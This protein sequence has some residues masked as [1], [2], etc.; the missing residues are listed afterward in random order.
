[1]EREVSKLKYIYVLVTFILASIVAINI[2]N[3]YKL[4]KSLNDLDTELSTVLS[5]IKWADLDNYLNDNADTVIYISDLSRDDKKIFELEFKKII[6]ENDLGDS[7]V[8]LDL[9]QMQE[10]D[11][12]KLSSYF[13]QSEYKNVNNSNYRS[14][15]IFFE[16][17]ITYVLT[18]PVSKKDTVS[19]K[20]V[21]IDEGVIDHG[22]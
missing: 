5:E 16:K 4:K 15:I 13:D 6:T 22:A 8:Y 17:E 7:I 1:M 21:L 2:I 10:G 9:N 19:L 20:K 12:D 14:L 11:Y 18:E 3:S